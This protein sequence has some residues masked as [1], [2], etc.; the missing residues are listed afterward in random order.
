MN[1][2]QSEHNRRYRE[3]HRALGLCT[4][5]PRPVVEGRSQC[6]LHGPAEPRV[7]RPPRVGGETQRYLTSGQVEALRIAYAGGAR[8]DALADMYGI[9]EGYAYMICEGH[10]RR[11]CPGPI[12]LRGSGTKLSDA[13]VAT[14]RSER[15]AG[16]RVKDLAVRYGLNAC[17]ACQVLRGHARA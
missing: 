17:Y 11:G 6:A 12:T 8:A 3:R 4:I 15:A 16:A 2:N 5:C 1:P 10:M 13:D 14:M 9:S 7:K